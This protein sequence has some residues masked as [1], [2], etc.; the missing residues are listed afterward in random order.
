MLWQAN[1]MPEFFKRKP[2]VVQSGFLE[3][4][5]PAKDPTGGTD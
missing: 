2:E 4:E 5:A 3:G 1:R